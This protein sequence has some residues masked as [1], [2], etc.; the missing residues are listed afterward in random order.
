MVNYRPFGKGGLGIQSAEYKTMALLIK[1]AI[2]LGNG[3]EYLDQRLLNRIRL[4][5][6]KETKEIYNFLLKEKIEKNGL[7]IPSRAETSISI[8]HNLRI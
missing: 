5:G 6:M 7:L 1:N 8:M 4:E 3:D 2:R